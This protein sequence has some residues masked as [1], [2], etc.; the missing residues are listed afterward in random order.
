MESKYA[1][2]ILKN[3]IILGVFITLVGIFVHFFSGSYIG[4]RLEGTW[5]VVCIHD[6]ITFIGNYFTRGQRAGEFRVRANL[7]FFCVSCSGYPIRITAGYV[8]INGVI[9]FRVCDET[10]YY[11][12]RGI[13]MS[14][15]L[16]TFKECKSCTGLSAH[17]PCTSE[18]RVLGGIIAKLNKE[19]KIMLAQLFGKTRD[20]GEKD[21][22]ETIRAMYKIENGL[23]PTMA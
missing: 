9:Y 11:L 23:A 19:E 13:Y 12:D 10:Y 8:M 17:E 5:R 2:K 16:G 22:L 18:R 14:D 20:A 3:T 21:M 7:I 1:V 6:E 15:C 4:E